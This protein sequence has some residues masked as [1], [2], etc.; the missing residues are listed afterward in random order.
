MCRNIFYVSILTGTLA[1]AGC[2]AADPVAYAGPPLAADGSPVTLMECRS[3]DSDAAL[4]LLGPL[5]GVLQLDGHRVELPLLAVLR[6]T[7]FVLSTPESEY[8]V[9]DIKAQGLLDFWFRRPISVTIDYSRC[10]RDAVP[11]GVWYIDHDTGELL[12]N[13]GGVNDPARRRIT[14]ITSHLSAYALAD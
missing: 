9:V 5:G 1:L 10:D 4:G 14:F 11:S 13:M 7:L 6:P 3:T 12:E 2:D 8:M